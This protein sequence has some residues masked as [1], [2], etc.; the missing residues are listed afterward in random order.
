MSEYKYEDFTF[1]KQGEYDNL[2]Q[3][4]KDRKDFS[5]DFNADAL[6]Q[7]YKDKYIGQGKMA[8]ADTMGQ[9]AAMT[10]GYGNSYAV[11]AGN[12]AY[13]NSLAN[14]NDIIPELYQMAYN[15][16]N[17]EGQDMLNKLS[18]LGD[19]RTFEYGEHSTK[20][21]YDYQNHRDGITD[22]QWAK[23]YALKMAASGL[24]EDENGNI[25]A[26]SGSGGSGGG[27]SVYVDASGNLKVSG[28]STGGVTQEIID[29]CKTLTSNEALSDYLAGLV[30]AGTID[31]IEAKDLL[32]KYTDQ[33]EIYNKD[34]K[35]NPTTI[36]YSEMVKNGEGFKVIDS[37]GG[38]LWGIDENARVELPNGKTMTLKNLKK[39]LVDDE[40]M[41]SSEATKLIKKL[42]QNLDI[43]SN[44]F[45]GA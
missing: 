8:M 20:Q 14:L 4:Y 9:A 18:I 19:E 26:S 17:Q 42:Q 2:Y 24:T 33:N 21:G 41:K 30:G 35:G 44:W 13:Q 6:Y 38:N 11:T 23:E 16:H 7:Q 40:G 3:Q 28:G 36:S 34:D 22:E 29:K 15:K 32:A 39:K 12:Q 10:G 31:T 5:Y 25:V 27:G 43:S 45:F 37:G 1:S